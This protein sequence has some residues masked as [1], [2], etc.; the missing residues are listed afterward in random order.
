MK[1]LVIDSNALQTEELRRFL[2]K[3]KQ[4]FAVLPD[5]AGIEA[6]KGDPLKTIFKSMKIVSEFPQQ[7]IILK[8]SEKVC[9]LSGRRKGLQR[10]LVDEKQTAGFADYIN[11][12][13]LAEAGNANIQ[14]QIRSL[15]VSANEHLNKMLNEVEEIRRASEEL[16]SHFTKEERA[17]LRVGDKYSP[18]L[19]NK[20]VLTVMEMSTLAFHHSP[21]V[22]RPPTYK[23]LP[24]TFIFRIIFACFLHS[25]RRFSQGGLGTINSEKLRNDLVD[26][27][28]VA[29]GSY[30]DGVMS[31]DQNV[32]Y[33][34]TETCL[35]LHSLLDAEVPFINNMQKNA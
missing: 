15:G 29:Y 28:F 19:I 16:G 18:E 10:R 34:Y 33:M 14:E 35:L 2:A 7:V 23:E 31:S 25:M 12:L 24:N 8:G 20:I 26:M 21:F 4:N 13:S 1:K 5:F 32:K 22:K 6:Y 17:L 27:M 9:N 11:A 30:F 3:S